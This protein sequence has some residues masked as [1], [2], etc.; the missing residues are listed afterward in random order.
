[1]LMQRRDVLVFLF[2]LTSSCFPTFGSGATVLPQ[3]EMD[4]LG[5]IGN[6][7]GKKWD[8][9][10]NPCTGESGW[11]G[12]SVTE[13]AV[14][15]TCPT[16]DTF[17]HVE[18][19][20]VSLQCVPFRSRIVTSAMQGSGLAWPARPAG[21]SFEIDLTRNYLRGTIPSEWGSMQL[22]T[23]SFLGN[24]ITGPIPKELWNI[25]TLTDLLLS[26]NVFS[27]QLPTSLANLTNLT[28]FRI[29][30]NNFTGSIPGFIKNWTELARLEIQGSGLQGPIPSEISSLVN[31]TDL[32]ISDI[33]GPATPFPKL[34]NMKSIRTLILRNCNLT[35][36]IPDYI[37]KMERLKTLD[38]SFNKLEGHLPPTL[39]KPRE[40]VFIYL[41]SNLLNG[42]VPEE[43][44]KVTNVD[45]SYNNFTSVSTV[46]CQDGNLNL[47]GSPPTANNLS[48]AVPCLKNFDC[49][50]SLLSKFYI[51]C[52]G[53]EV[54][55]RVNGT[56]RATT[57]TEDQDLG[58]ASKYFLSRER[59]A[60]SSTGNFLDDD[61]VDSYI[62]TGKNISGLTMPDSKLYTKARL[63]PL[64]LTYIGLCLWNGNYT[65]NL[66]FAEIMFAD[67]ESYSSL[68][69]RL[70]DIYIQGKLVWKDF[71]IEAEAGGTHKAVVRN[72]TANVTTN[73][74]EIRF[75]WA[76]KGTQSL[77]YRGTYGPLISAI[78]VVS[79]FVPPGNGKKM[80]TAAV[81]GIVL[82]A[83]SLIFLVLGILWK[84]GCLGSKSRRDQELRGLDLRTGSFTLGQIKAA[85]NNF[86]VSNKIGEGGFGSVYKGVLLDGTIIA[87]KQLS[88]KSRQG[89]REFLNEIG[90][91]SALQHPNLVKLYGCCIEAK[92][93]LLVYEYMENNS[94]AS[95]LFGHEECQLLLDWP[96]RHKI[97]V[98]IARG[99]AFLHEESTLKVVHRDIKA[100]NIL[101]D[102]DLNPKIS[103]F[104]LARLHE[105][106]N[107]HISTR[108][109][110]TLG[111]MAPEYAMHGYLTDKADVYSF[112]VVTL[113]IV[114]GKNITSFRPKGD[115][116]H[117]VD[118]A[119]VLQAKGNL[120]ELVDLKLGPEF[121]KDEAIRM[122]NVALLCTNSSPTLRPTMS[123][124]VSMLEGHAVI[125]EV[126]SDPSLSTGI[127]NFKATIDHYERVQTQ[128]PSPSQTLI[129][130]VDRPW[131][132]S[133]TSAQ[134]L[135]PV[136]L[137]S[138]YLSNRE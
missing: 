13:N 43:L 124:L 12:P 38:L 15:C 47:F 21:S 75:Y 56:H 57:F 50:K 48:G 110:G 134:D 102:R 34:D 77:P 100:T 27:G 28:D 86:N 91:F 99:L 120:L 64:S 10:A 1:M 123:A 22:V 108:I 23:I 71:N 74:L 68:G 106:E 109:A 121:N 88:S 69:K 62:Y 54:T 96:T 83:V 8:L 67:N 103:D 104:G 49:S 113:E 6:S 122:I 101:L 7:L 46:H 130:S 33:N 31:L 107:T 9:T 52:G 53:E 60:F 93:L 78:S 117:L 59:W 89:N 126:V 51:N 136:T 131:T 95:A 61:S 55:V 44:K 45:L 135:Y 97:C 94:L 90:M 66:H 4:A 111:Y 128:S 65:V 30:D 3:E 2:L 18:S 85:T 116:I 129:S 41:T 20:R 112:G 19:I 138:Q 84:R 119:Y 35:G 73:T 16:N 115:H 133:S 137:S 125:Q 76:G 79:D 70:F 80:P 118:W 36:S 63:S 29:N 127:W 37:W 58:G 92:Q 11:L 72:F 132:D 114:S 82:S 87:V 105:E 42:P 39:S 17:C 14:N 32:R 25:S 26:S 81:A 24:R 98:G 5:Q 40:A